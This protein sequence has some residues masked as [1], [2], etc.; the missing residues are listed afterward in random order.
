MEN[1][2]LFNRLLYCLVFMLFQCLAWA[3]D[4]GNPTAIE[5]AHLEAINRARLAPFEE[6]ARLGIDLFEGVSSGE[7]TGQPV[8]PLSSNAQLLQIARQH[9]EDMLLRNFFAHNNLEGE[10]PFDRM[11]SV[12]YSLQTAGENIAFRG[13]TGAID[14]QLIGLML[15][16][17]LF[18]DIDYPGRGHRVNILK[19]D[20]REV[21]VGLGFGVFVQ[22]GTAFNSGMVTTDFATQQNDS[23]IILGVVYDDQNNNQL[24]DAGEGLSDVTVAILESGIQ[25][26]TAT[27]G[28]YRVEVVANNDYQLVFSHPLYGSVV[29]LASVG[30][31]NVKV[32]AILSE[33]SGGTQCAFVQE[34]QLT[35]PCVSVEG[36]NYSAHLAVQLTDP[37]QFVLNTANEVSSHFA[38]CATFDSHTLQVHL[39]CVDVGG[40]RYQATL[41]WQQNSP[42]VFELLDFGSI[43]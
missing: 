9:S 21:G 26:L 25:T 20:F 30:Q 12:G 31:E 32:D 5:Q 4:Y 2:Y 19:P 16:D 22:D 11:A 39:P 36:V 29:K 42:S 10:S 41:A 14:E 43:E 18:L 13:S 24:Y 38:Q 35:I 6:A 15:H 3:G 28:G 1:M 7:I 40:Q 33:F 23:P 27:A 37:L 17:D 34:S 8:Q